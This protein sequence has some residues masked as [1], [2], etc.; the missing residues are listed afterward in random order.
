VH[1]IVMMSASTVLLTIAVL[2]SLVEKPLI[3]VLRV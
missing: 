3:R 2:W 1:H